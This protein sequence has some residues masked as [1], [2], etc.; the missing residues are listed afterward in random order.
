MPPTQIAAAARPQVERLQHQLALPRYTR[1]DAGLDQLSAAFVHRALTQLGWQPDPGET[2]DQI[3][4]AHRLGVHPKHR[5]LWRRM[6]EILAEESV[7]VRGDEAHWCVNDTNRW[8]DD[9]FK[10]VDE[11]SAQFSECNAELTLLRQCGSALAGVLTGRTDPLEVLFPSGSSEMVERLYR[12]SPFARTLNAVIEESI[13]KSIEHVTADRPI[14]ILEIGAGTGGTT[15][16]LLHR[17]PAERTE[18]LFTDVS[19]L[20]TRAAAQRFAE[21]PFVRYGL[22]DIEV[23]PSKQGYADHQ[24]D[25]ILAANVLHATQ[26]LGETLQHIQQL[27]VPGGTLVVA[28]TTRRQRWLDLIFGLTEGWWRFSD[29]ELRPDH[30]LLSP[31]QWTH[32]FEKLEF[33]SAAAL[34]SSI[35][36]AGSAGVPPHAVLVA[37]TA[38]IPSR[39]EQPSQLPAAQKAES[40]LLLS[41]RQGVGDRLA[42]DLEHAGHHC[43]RVYAGA[44]FAQLGENRFEVNPAQ[45]G[46]LGQLFN[47]A[48]VTSDAGGLSGVLHLWSLD[49]VAHPDMDAASLQRSQ[50]L[51]AVSVPS[52]LRAISQAFQAQS[53]TWFV[54]RGAQPIPGDTEMSGL[55]QSPLIGLARVVSQELP[56][57]WG[58]LIDLDPKCGSEIS[59]RQIAAEVLR[60]DTEDQVAY[61]HGQRFAARLEPLAFRPAPG[62]PRCHADGSYLITGGLG[63]LGLRVAEWLAARGARN[64]VLTGRS[65]VAWTTDPASGDPRGPVMERLRASGVAVRAVT[66]DVADEPEMQS[67]FANLTSDGW[68]PIRGIVHCAGVADAL[69]LLELSDELIL[70]A[71]RAKV[72]GTW[73]LHRLTASV[74]LDFFVSFSSGATLLGSPLLGSYAA[75]NTFLDAVAHLRRS[76]GENA[77][78]VNWGFWDDVGMVSRTQ[79]E[80]GHGFC[81]SGDAVIFTRASVTGLGATDAR[82]RDPIGGDAR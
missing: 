77:L 37:Q 58:G 47:V 66:V 2:F 13:I 18:Y 36:V 26:D 12:D 80:M 78:T 45:L 8:F 49:A 30:P 20:F 33:A 67:L 3:Q 19:E 38:A 43:L 62:S 21:F 48:D 56:A 60:P 16:Q 44:C 15:A 34:P 63:D 70:A 46:D 52:L 75:A 17:L 40:W 4:L 23:D 74:P 53:R 27:L 50:Q 32:L 39:N 35:E 69:P 11:L 54:T 68:P 25:L 64:L 72:T 76:L 24:F 65:S 6:L 5:R 55:A 29:V 41:D 14:K 22:L 10:L 42:D 57:L 9:P 73:V 59:A 51:G 61:R 31:Q 82:R 28:E 1:L 81:D 79:K 71:F 7:L